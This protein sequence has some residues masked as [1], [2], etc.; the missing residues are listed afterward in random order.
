MAMFLH[1]GASLHGHEYST[2]PPNRLQRRVPFLRSALRPMTDNDANGGYPTPPQNRSD[3]SPSPS[4]TPT[5][6]LRPRSYTATSPLPSPDSQRLPSRPRP[7]SDILKK[8]HVRFAETAEELDE[9]PTRSVE[10]FRQSPS[11]E[12][13]LAGHSEDESAYSEVSDGDTSLP[14]VPRKRKRRAPRSGTRYLVAQPPPQTI[15]KHRRFHLRH[16]LLLQLQQLTDKRPK[17]AFDVLHPSV[18]RKG[19]PK[20]TGRFPNPFGARRE[21]T[22]DDLILTRSEDY[23]SSTT[24]DSSDE[25]G[26]R[27][28]VAVI[29]PRSNGDGRTDIV[30]TDGTI[31]TATAMASGSYEFT[32]TGPD[33]TVVT[34]RWAKRKVALEDEDNYKYTFS[35]IDPLRRRH[36]IMGTLTPSTL[37]VLDNY[38]TV[39][40][41]SSGRHPPTR[42]FSIEGNGVAQR[43][44]LPVDERMR[45]FITVSGVA[46]SLVKLGVTMTPKMPCPSKEKIPAS[47]GSN[48]STG[49]ARN[50]SA[51]SR[52][53][54]L[55]AGYPP[56][57][58]N[59][60]PVGESL[61]PMSATSDGVV[62]RWTVSGKRRSDI[63][64]P[65]ASI[66]RRSDLLPAQEG[67]E[68][69]GDGAAPAAPVAPVAPVERGVSLTG[70]GEKG[71]EKEGKRRLYS[72][73]KRVFGIGRDGAK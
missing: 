37:E 59:T 20:L 62:R 8:D 31:W 19:A 35:I 46:L 23:D 12:R 65:S 7:R 52:K 53:V 57:R 42:P 2:P 69:L 9:S 3:S 30:L 54:S 6:N 71:K 25:L 22:S 51:H 55:P 39:S 64:S 56:G 26:N 43:T 72:R 41:H 28:V 1:S 44:T 58:N 27:E 48:G 32:T 40:P 47:P 36:P 50:V 17:P 11:P 5:K 15:K 16:T 66:K 61:S 13:S 60:A 10:Q 33:G 4:H 34:A 49:H 21:L 14:S 73:I 67:E 18:L 63:G 38:T 45:M 70:E 24:D 68:V 29:S